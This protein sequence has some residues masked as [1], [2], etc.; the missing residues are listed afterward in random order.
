MVFCLLLRI[1]PRCPEPVGSAWASVNV[2]EHPRANAICT[3]K[4]CLGGVCLLVWRR[5][6]LSW[7]GAGRTCRSPVSAPGAGEIGQPAP[8]MMPR[9]GLDTALA[10]F[11]IPGSAIPRHP[12]RVAAQDRGFDA[13]HASR[14]Q[15]SP[16]CCLPGLLD[17]SR[18]C[19]GIRVPTGGKSSVASNPVR[20]EV[21]SSAP[22]ACSQTSIQSC[23]RPLWH[24]L[25]GIGLFSA[26]AAVTLAHLRVRTILLRCAA[27][28][29]YL[30]G[31]CIRVYLIRRA[32]RSR[33][34]C[35]MCLNTSSP[36]FGRN[37]N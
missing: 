23:L 5:G 11:A 31:D 8:D 13:E 20:S 25:C 30:I 26:F 3:V 28:G 9:S 33:I 34:P 18:K 19:G 16:L 4:H 7:I 27:L 6:G 2:R 35:I 17:Q 14:A 29:C 21:S 1:A 37:D 22:Q 15:R 10:R 24:V 12:R 36:E 32:S